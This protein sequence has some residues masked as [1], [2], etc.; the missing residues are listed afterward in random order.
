LNEGK[1]GGG[2]V[3]RGNKGKKG[4]PPRNQIRKGEEKKIGRLRYEKRGARKGASTITTQEETEQNGARENR[5]GRG[6]LL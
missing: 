2:V 3:K 5:G 1:S 4:R 6:T